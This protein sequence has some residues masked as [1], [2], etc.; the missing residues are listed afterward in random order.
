MIGMFAGKK[1][2]LIAVAVLVVGLISFTTIRYIQSA[3]QDKVTIELQEKQVEKRKKID[4]AVR[5][6]PSTVNDSLQY[7]Q[8]R[9]GD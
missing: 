8:R 7:L 9:Q 6:S 2:I 5:N 1:L 4:R 3:E